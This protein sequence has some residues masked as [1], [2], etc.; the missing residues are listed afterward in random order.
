MGMGQDGIRWG[1]TQTGNQGKE[2]GG[3]SLF[4]ELGLK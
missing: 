1:Q 2:K 4:L 3:G